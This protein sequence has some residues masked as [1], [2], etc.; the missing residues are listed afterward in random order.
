MLSLNGQ[1][2]LQNFAAGMGLQLSNND[3]PTR[4]SNNKRTFLDLCF[5]TNEQITRW[6]IGLPLF[7]IDHNVIF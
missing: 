3:I 7:D 5:S 6:K 4:I 1:K 2:N